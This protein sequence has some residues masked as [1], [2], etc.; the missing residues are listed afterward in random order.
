VIQQA[1]APGEPLADDAVAR[2]T[3]SPSGVRVAQ[4]AREPQREAVQ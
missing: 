1:P 4:W 2:L 3:L